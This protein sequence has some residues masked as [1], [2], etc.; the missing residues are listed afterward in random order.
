MLHLVVNPVAGGGRAERDAKRL[1]ARLTELGR[2]FQTYHS[3]A[4]GDAERLVRALPDTEPVVAVGGDGTVSEVVSGILLSGHRSAFCASPSGSG[5]D[6]ARALGWKTLDDTLRAFERDA[7]TRVDL[8]RVNSRI[9]AYGLGVGFDAQVAH[10]ALHLPGFLRGL[11]RY[12]YAILRVLPG[13]ETPYLKL[14][15]DGE[16]VYQGKSVLAAAMNTPTA[17]GGFRLAPDA[18]HSDGLLDI[19][20]GGDLSKLETFAILPR[21]IAGT[22]VTHQKV[23]VF[24]ARHVRLEWD[25][26]MYAHVDGEQLPRTRAFEVECLPAALEI[27]G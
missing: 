15:A 14:I 16:T 11:P 27:F 18:D 2:S 9:A 12:L 20:V 10:E 4:P 26:A 24:R 22:H 19:V 6:F 13:L 25:R 3:A 8:V 5:N 21:V 17:G 23:R 1:E 7:R